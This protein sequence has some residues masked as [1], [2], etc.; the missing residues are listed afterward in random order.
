MKKGL[1]TIWALIG[2]IWVPTVS[3][4]AGVPE[5][6]LRQCREKAQKV[7]LTSVS[8]KFGKLIMDNTKSSAQVREYCGSEIAAGCFRHTTAA[9][10]YGVSDYLK[11]DVGNYTCV[12][13]KLYAAY[14]W[15][16][17]NIFVKKEYNACQRRV[18]LRHEL[19][20]FTI[21]KTA[22]NN[23]LTESKKA[24]NKLALNNIQV[25]SSDDMG[26]FSGMLSLSEEIGRYLKNI[27]AE[28][29]SIARKNDALLDKIDHNMETEVNYRVCMPYS[30][31]LWR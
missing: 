7:K 25:F 31:E 30:I 10:H 15:V 13:P 21:W 20:H 29:N 5:H 9:Y 22:Q 6:I 16:D 3:N 23:I 4:A 8:Y 18:V 27:N 1:W 19:Q 26:T 24:L 28:W 14:S 2:L 17:V 11:F 12:V